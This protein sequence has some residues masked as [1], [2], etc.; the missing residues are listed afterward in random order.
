[1]IKKIVKCIFFHY[2][3]IKNKFKTKLKMRKNLKDVWKKKKK[4]EI[5]IKYDYNDSQSVGKN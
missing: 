1:M 4:T 3:S 2:A 5:E